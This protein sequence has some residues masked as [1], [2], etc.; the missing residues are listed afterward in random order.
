MSAFFGNYAMLS[1]LIRRLTVSAEVKIVRVYMTEAD[2]MLNAVMSYL[3]FEAK[4]QGV[5]VFKAVLGYGKSGAMHTAET[6]AAQGES[7]P[8]VLEFFDMEEKAN[9]AI[10]TLKHMLGANHIVSWKVQMS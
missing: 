4:V 1:P 9:E 10:S 5:S 7:M 3:H 2:K 6:A 8:I